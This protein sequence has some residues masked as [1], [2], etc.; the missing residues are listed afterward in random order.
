MDSGGGAT[1]IRMP[2]RHIRDAETELVRINNDAQPPKEEQASGHRA[3]RAW[4]W[5]SWHGRRRHA[6]RLG[7][8][9][10]PPHP[11]HP[12]FRNRPCHDTVADFVQSY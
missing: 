6:V 4:H 8:A 9:A 1:A 5:S 2:Y 3:G 10:L 11:I 7:A 12:D